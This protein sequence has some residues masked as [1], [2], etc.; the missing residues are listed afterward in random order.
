MK[1]TRFFAIAMAA[2]SLAACS[3]ENTE[4]NKA[5]G[6]IGMFM[7]IEG[8]SQSGTK[9]TGNEETTGKITFDNVTVYF[10]DAAGSIVE[11]QSLSSTA[12]ATEWANLTSAGHIFHGIPNTVEQVYVVGNAEG[13]NLTGAT[14]DA[15]K[16]QVLKV[17]AEQNFD[18]VIIAGICEQIVPAKGVT[19]PEGHEYLYEAEVALLP[20][21]SRMEI[22]GI[23]C[24]NLDDSK[25][26]KIELQ[27]IGL[28]NYFNNFNLNGEGSTQMTIDNLLNP[29]L[30]E[31]EYIFGGTAE[32]FDWAWD[33][34]NKEVLNASSTIIYPEGEANRYVYQFFT[35]KVSD[36][37]RVKLAL[38]AYYRDSGALDP[39]AEAVT[40]KFEGTE[41]AAGKIYQ[42]DSFAFKAE[43]MKPWNPTEDICISVNVTVSDWEIVALTPTF[44]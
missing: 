28:F 40:A 41:F 18:D 31:G 6:T 38:N 32:G 9:A 34:L 25:Y 3:K 21:I 11:T 14:I 35:G 7:K 44:E 8:L 30:S 1:I 24:S 15:I 23:Q 10:A 36:G 20:F 17:A 39:R 22:A 29:D 2:L 5:D 42:I 26:N 33:N 12:N 13:K 19:D 37:L 16:S 43:D 27:A 4:N